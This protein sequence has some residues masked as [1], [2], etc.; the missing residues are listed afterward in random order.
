MHGIGWPL[1]ESNSS[2]GAFLYH[3][4]NHEVYL[5]LIADLNYSNPHLSP[6]EE[7]QRWK[8]HPKTK[9]VLEGG[10]RIAYGAP[11]SCK[12]R[13]KLSP[14]DGI[15]GWHPRRLRRGYA[16]QCED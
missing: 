10:E 6:F 2:G 3:A 11:R 16:Q 7:F 8:T 4:E 1:S 12:R 9:E 14:G 13:S 5:G 15:P